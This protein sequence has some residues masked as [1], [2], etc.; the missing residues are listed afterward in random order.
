[1]SS[2]RDF[3]DWILITSLVIVTS[4]GSVSFRAIVNLIFAGIFL[5]EFYIGDLKEAFWNQSIVLLHAEN[6]HLPFIQTLLIKFSVAIGIIIASIFYFYNQN[7]ASKT[8]KKFKYLYF[9]S[10]NKWYVDEIYNF[11]IVKP[12]FRIS[13]IFWKKGD[14]KFIDAYGPNGVSKLISNSSIYFSRLQS[15]YVYHYAFVMLGGLIIILTW[16]IF[17]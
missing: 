16:F 17:Y 5:V 3:T 13:D 14:I 12:Y 2:I 7:I 9:I 4:N 15:G 8:S 10:F 1:M 11:L 6:H